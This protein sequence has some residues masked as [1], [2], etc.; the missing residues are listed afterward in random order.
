[1]TEANVK[2]IS[3]KG[4]A[5]LRPDIKRCFQL[6]LKFRNKEDGEIFLGHETFCFFGNSDGSRPIDIYEARVLGDQWVQKIV[7]LAQ[8]AALIKA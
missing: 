1:M 7:K 6:N 4:D 8:Y 3:W 2:K 5:S